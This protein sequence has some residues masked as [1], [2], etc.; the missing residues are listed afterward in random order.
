[1]A[2]PSSLREVRAQV[3]TTFRSAL[4]NAGADGDWN[5]TNSVVHKLRAVSVDTSGLTRPGIDD[6]TLQTRMHSKPAMI[7]GMRKG[8]AKVVCYA[9]GAFANTETPP[10]WNIVH[11]MCGG[12]NVPS[13]RSALADGQVSTT[14]VQCTGVGTA[15]GIGRGM[16][17]LIGSRNDGRGGAEVKPINAITADNIEFGVACSAAPAVGD[18]MVFSTTLYPDEDATQKYVDLLILGHASADQIQ[19]IGGAGPFSVSGT[20]LGELPKIELSPSMADWEY[21]ASGS[22]ASLQHGVSPHGGSPAFDRAIGLVHIGDKD[23]NTRVA[24]KVADFSFNPGLEYAEQ[25]SPSGVNGL[26][27]HQH[28]PGVPT[29]EMTIITGEDDGVLSDFPDTEKTVMVQYGHEA[30]KCIAFELQSAYL[31]ELPQRVEV[32]SLSG[33]R[34]KFH[35]T[36]DYVSGANCQ[37]AAWRIHIF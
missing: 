19:A 36:E 4:L 31:D 11:A 21:C 32:G 9:G 24:Y 14:N 17:V 27:G 13:N 22:R 1:M 23:T 29:M 5:T 15:L 35:G 20:A 30:T 34:L 26:E 18:T 33:W 8:T 16:A 28:M 37:S 25:P 12:A 6:E 10:E 2:S 3:S 7:A